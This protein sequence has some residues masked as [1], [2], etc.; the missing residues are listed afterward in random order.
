MEELHYISFFNNGDESA[1]QYLF[2]LFYHPLYFFAKGLTDTRL[3][4][5]DLVQDAFIQLWKHREGFSSFRSVKAFLYLA[6]KNSSRNLYKH[7]KVEGRYRQGQKE[8]LGENVIFQRII[9]A[10]V[11]DEVHKALQKLPEGCRKVINLCY[12]DGL[13]NQEA[14]TH[15]KVSVNTIKTHKLRALRILRLSVRH[16]FIGCVLLMAHL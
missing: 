4:A 8:V 6:V 13:S 14:A 7:K 9:E 12:F 11:L 3:E 1:F 5:E 16:I 15:L 2:N 10:E